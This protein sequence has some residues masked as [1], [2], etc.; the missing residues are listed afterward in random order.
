MYIIVFA[1]EVCTRSIACFGLLQYALHRTFPRYYPEVV[2]VA[3]AASFNGI[4]LGGA[5]T[6]GIQYLCQH[7]RLTESELSES[8]PCLFL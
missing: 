3:S 1:L 5:N 6:I 8:P 7:L 4:I 2:Q